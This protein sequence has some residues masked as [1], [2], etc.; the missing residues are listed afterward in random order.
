VIATAAGTA[1]IWLGATGGSALASA[2]IE[3][4]WSFRGGRV[5]VAVGPGGVATGTVL[6]RTTFDTCPHPVG[7]R[8]WVGLRRRPGGS[9]WGAHQWFRTSDCAPLPARGN[10]ALRVLR[11]PDGRLFLRACFASPQTPAVQPL[12]AADGTSIGATGGCADSDLFEPPATRPPAL[13]DVA[14]LPR[15]GRRGCLP[16]RPLRIALR[17]PQGDALL[18]A[19]VTVNGAPAA[20]VT[21]DGVRSGVTVR[22]LPRG[23]AR[24]RVLV[25]TV[26]G[27]TLSGTRAY[28]TCARSRRR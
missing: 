3:G 17:D 10:T 5:V 7:E 26:L 2:D 28:R 15:R 14:S 25:T 21:G 24:V 20:A 27:R 12:L 16:R 11:R 6:R 4:T 23:R 18:T 1:A 19:A 22:R 8:I 9:W 13:R